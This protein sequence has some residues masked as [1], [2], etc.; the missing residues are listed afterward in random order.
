MAVETPSYWNEEKY[1]PLVETTTLYGNKVKVPERYKD[2]WGFF[3][4][5][6]REMKIKIDH[7][8]ADG[9]RQARTR[10]KLIRDLELVFYEIYEE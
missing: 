1:Q 5:R 3:L 7:L 9:L 8:K 4:R 10:N 2:T 6:K